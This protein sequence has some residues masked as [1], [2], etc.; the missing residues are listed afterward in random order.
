MFP[1]SE[2]SNSKVHVLGLSDQFLMDVL[3]T[4][5]VQGSTILLHMDDDTSAVKYSEE[6]TSF[7]A[8]LL[9]RDFDRSTGKESLFDTAVNPS[10]QVYIVIRGTISSVQGSDDTM[11]L[12]SHLKIPLSLDSYVVD[13]ELKEAALEKNLLHVL[14]AHE[15]P[16]HQI[17]YKS[18]LTDL[19]LHEDELEANRERML[20]Y[21][22][23]AKNDSLLIA[24]DLLD[25]ISDCEAAELAAQEQIREAKKNLH[26]SSQQVVPYKSLSQ[27]AGCM[28]RCIQKLSS[29]LQYF[30]LGVSDFE[31]IL[32]DV[33]SNYKSTKVSDNTLSIKAHVIHLKWELMLRVYQK[34]QVRHKI[35]E[36]TVYNTYNVIDVYV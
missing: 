35:S 12:N 8:R 23:D 17:L 36:A 3:R 25:T 2:I 19:A 5:V 7:L 10:L 28:L 9:R 34:L 30:S 11:W 15:R 18:L 21:V 29:I 27:Y 26:A 6:D 14:I 24:K 33:I 4:A 32:S 1:Y 22:L 20:K 13:I 31:M 16:D